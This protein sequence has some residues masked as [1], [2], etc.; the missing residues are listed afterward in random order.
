MILLLGAVH[1]IGIA[2]G[3]FALGHGL[4]IGFWPLA[5]GTLGLTVM[6]AHFSRR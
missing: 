2:L 5:T 6:L 1:M 3:G 4:N